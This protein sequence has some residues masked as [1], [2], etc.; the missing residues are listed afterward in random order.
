MTKLSYSKDAL[1]AKAKFYEKDIS[2]YVEGRDDVL[3]WESSFSR[4]GVDAHVEEMGNTN[5]IAKLIKFILNDGAK[6]CVA[7]DSDHSDFLDGIHYHSKVLRT[8]GYSIENSMYNSTSL[9]KIISKLCRKRVSV[10][11]EINTWKHD[12][13]ESI[14][15]LIV[16]DIANHKFNKKIT[17][18]GDSCSRFLKSKNSYEVSTSKI[19]EFINEIK[20][21]FSD[22]EINEVESLI[23]NS[24]KNNWFHIKGHFLS[25]AV[26][27]LILYQ[28]KKNIGKKVIFNNEHL[29]SETCE[30]ILNG[31]EKEED[32]F[33]I[34]ENIKNI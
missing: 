29:Y 14:K 25:L 22:D 19:D 9:E 3:F 33:Y 15:K 13:T 31:D 28:V 12:F 24:P 34:L 8:Y 17:V 2:V 23:G 32:I 20:S 1:E 4:I 7:T 16:Y 26:R 18:L 10:V 21:S 27:N 11:P 5:E 30:C 6:F